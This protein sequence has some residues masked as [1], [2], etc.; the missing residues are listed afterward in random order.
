MILGRNELENLLL[1]GYAE[2]G[3]ANSGS[4]GAGRYTFIGPRFAAPSALVVGPW[5]EAARDAAIRLIV[6]H[7][8]VDKLPDGFVEFRG[9][10]GEV[11][12]FDRMTC[13]AWQQAAPTT[14]CTQLS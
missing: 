14:E 7:T 3:P 11:W 5:D 9:H 1:E 4:R 6:R 13:E 8:K 12:T 2:D 10:R